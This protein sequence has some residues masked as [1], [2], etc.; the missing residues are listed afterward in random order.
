MDSQKPPEENRR[1]FISRVSSGAMTLGLVAGYGTLA[2]MGT[3]F[4][5]PS[6]EQKQAWLYVAKIDQLDVGEVLKYVSPI[7]HAITITRRQDT[8]TLDD[9]LALS[10]TC[11]HLGCQVHWES[12]NQ[13]FFC[14]CHNG[15]FDPEGKATAG[16][17]ADAEQSLPRYPLK[18]EQGL[19]FIQVPVEKLEG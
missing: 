16:P 12:Q 13:R 9:F 19:L 5:Y 14:P 17:P 18:I 4:L 7:G 2:V 6:R 15:A 8:G 1:T 10:S 3:Q 11:P